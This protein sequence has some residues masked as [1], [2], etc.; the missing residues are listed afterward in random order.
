MIALY[1]LNRPCLPLYLD[2]L[3]DSL[4]LRLKIYECCRISDVIYGPETFVYQLV[5]NLQWAVLPLSMENSL[6]EWKQNQFMKFVDYHLKKY[7]LTLKFI[8]IPAAF[9]KSKENIDDL[10]LGSPK[11]RSSFKNRRS[12]KKRTSKNR[13][14]KFSDEKT[15]MSEMDENDI[16]EE[17]DSM[18]SAPGRSE[19]QSNTVL[20]YMICLEDSTNELYVVF[21]GTKLLNDVYHDTFFSD[22]QV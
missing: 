5:T 10:L 6:N 8:H 12:N 11:N 7:G 21:K 3:T 17:I 15:K 19:S 16:F 22:L 4:Q 13:N 20:Q 14:V 18:N 1:V 9:M 2:G